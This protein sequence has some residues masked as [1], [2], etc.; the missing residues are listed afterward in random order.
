MKPELCHQV[1]HIFLYL[2]ICVKVS[3]KTITHT[4]MSANLAV[5][6]CWVSRRHSHDFAASWDELLSP[7]FP[8]G[9]GGMSGELAAPSRA[10][11]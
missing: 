3:Q 11:H 6:F 7:E 10:V 9:L 2:W 4:P 8:A 1:R 5:A